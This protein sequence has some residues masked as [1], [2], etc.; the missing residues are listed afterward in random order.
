QKSLHALTPRAFGA[1][2]ERKV[3]AVGCAHRQHLPLERLACEPFCLK[4]P[5]LRSPGSC[6]GLLQS[7]E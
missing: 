6:S 4:R 1:H 2:R 7:R 5:L 3:L